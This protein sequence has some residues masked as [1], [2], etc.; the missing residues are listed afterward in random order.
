[1]TNSSGKILVTGGGGYIGVVLAEEL[2]KRGYVVKLLDTFYWGF[3]PI[4]QIKDKVEIV[5]ADIQIL[6]GHFLQLIL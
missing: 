6:N 3:E 4:R 1:M 5:Q 2:L